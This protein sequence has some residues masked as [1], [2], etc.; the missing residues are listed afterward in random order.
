MHLEL[1][2]IHVSSQYELGIGLH[3]VVSL[4]SG[5]N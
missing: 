3:H 4:E 2:V 1:K 5:A